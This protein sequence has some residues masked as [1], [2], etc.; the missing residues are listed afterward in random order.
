MI[1]GEDILELLN[2]LIDKDLLKKM[3]QRRHVFY[4][5]K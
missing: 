1:T 2:R 4:C 5:L 3:R